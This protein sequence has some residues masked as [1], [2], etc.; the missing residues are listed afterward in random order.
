[1]YQ[2]FLK[3]DYIVSNVI[4]KRLST[5]VVWQGSLKVNPSVMIGSFLAGILPCRLAWNKPCNF[6]FLKGCKFKFAA[7]PNLI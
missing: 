7:W 1:M 4:K 6:V 3:V 2:L 5:F